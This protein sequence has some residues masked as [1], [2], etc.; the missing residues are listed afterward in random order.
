MANVMKDV[1]KLLGVELEE[2]FKIKGFINKCKL[3]TYGLM[4]WSDTSQDWVLSS[5]IGELLNGLDEIVKLH[6]PQKPILTDKE[7]E[8]LSNVIKPFRDRIISIRKYR[9]NQDEYIG[10]Y[11]KYYAETDENEMITLPVLKEGTIYK[12]MKLNIEYLL[13]ELGL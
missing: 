7:K 1:A 11:I 2:E 8:Y 13:E 4:C 10:M 5:A 3:S 6:E 12:G 9:F